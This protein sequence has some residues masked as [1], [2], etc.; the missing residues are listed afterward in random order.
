MIN[1]NIIVGYL[2]KDN[3]EHYKIA[4]DFFD[5]IKLRKVRAY[6]LTLRS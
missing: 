5:L 2:T 3:V 4:R 6:L 1:T